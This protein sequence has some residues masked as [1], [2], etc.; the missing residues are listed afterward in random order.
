MFFKETLFKMT[1]QIN[2]IF[3]GEGLWWGLGRGEMN[4]LFLFP[5]SHVFSYRTVRF[6]KLWSHDNLQYN[7]SNLMRLCCWHH[8]HKL[9]RDN[10]YLAIHSFQKG[11]KEPILQSILININF[12]II[13]IAIKLIKTTFKIPMKVKK[14]KTY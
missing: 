4:P 7:L 9:W 2:H 14:F 12:G 10:F 1:H 8:Q 13:S 3:D 6:T 11:L 5:M